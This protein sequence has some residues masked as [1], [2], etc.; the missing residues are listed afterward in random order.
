MQTKA[1]DNNDNNDNDDDDDDQDDDN[2][3]NRNKQTDD[4]NIVK[5]IGK[6][7]KSILKSN[8]DQLVNSHSQNGQLQVEQVENKQQ[9]QQPQADKQQPKLPNEN[10]RRSLVRFSKDLP[11]NNSET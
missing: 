6:P 3:D 8:A 5:P 1:V 7:L 9:P 11:L 2:N 4:T 10:R